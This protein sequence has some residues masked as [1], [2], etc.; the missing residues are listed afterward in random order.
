MSDIISK[1]KL[2]KAFNEHCYGECDICHYYDSTCTLIKDAPSIEERE[3]VKIIWSAQ[4]EEIK[5][6]L[7]GLK[8][9]TFNGDVYL[10]IDEV[11]EALECVK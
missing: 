2:L 9:Y 7:Y 6:C 3:A 8:P 4:I 11:I 5:K 1:R 10:K